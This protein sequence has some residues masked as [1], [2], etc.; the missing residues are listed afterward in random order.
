MRSKYEA[1]GMDVNIE[2]QRIYYMYTSW[3]SVE[4]YLSNLIRLRYGPFNSNVNLAI[5]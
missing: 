1:N 4:S 2:F 3:A 5:L